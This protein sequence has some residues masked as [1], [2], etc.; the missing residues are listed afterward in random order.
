MIFLPT[1]FMVLTAYAAYREAMWEYRS[2][3][4][5]IH[6]MKENDLYQGGCDMG[7]DNPLYEWDHD[8]F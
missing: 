2:T 3:R 8:E 5:G 6:L 4:E 1:V 7:H